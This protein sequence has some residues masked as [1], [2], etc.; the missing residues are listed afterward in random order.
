[1]E[2][3]FTKVCADLDINKVEDKRAAVKKM[4]TMIMKLAN[5]VEM[6]H[7]LKKM[8]EKINVEENILRETLKATLAEIK[9]PKELNPTRRPVMTVVL[10]S[11]SRE[12]KLSELLLALMLKYPDFIPYTANNLESEYLAGA[13]Q[14]L[15]YNELIIY[16]NDNSQIE[17]RSFRAHL[18]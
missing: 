1:M 13:A 16:Y 9:K 11:E 2:Y 8:S 12:E 18:E 7:W 15:F 6:D 5:R 4:L 14:R 10:A 17:Y 3:Y